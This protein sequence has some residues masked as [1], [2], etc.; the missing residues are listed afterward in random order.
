MSTW[1]LSLGVA[2]ETPG[3]I[4]II[5]EQFYQKFTNLNIVDG[6]TVLDRD[7]YATAM[8]LT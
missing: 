7:I 3:N 5:H 8:K 1:A 4:E 6:N 2:V